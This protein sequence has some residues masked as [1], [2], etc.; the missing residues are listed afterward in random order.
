MTECEL[1]RYIFELVPDMRG[2]QMLDP[3]FYAYYVFTAARRFFFFLDP[4]RSR[5]VSIKKLAHSTIMEELMYLQRIASYDREINVGDAIKS[6]WFSG[7]NA[8]R[9][10]YKFIRLDRDK[11]GT[12]LICLKVW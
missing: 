3:S 7:D 9:V 10:Y 4:K 12:I 11:N 1:E 5:R 2:C 6:N 8:L